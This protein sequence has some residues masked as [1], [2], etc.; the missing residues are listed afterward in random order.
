MQKLSN[1]LHVKLG[2][3]R[4]MQNQLNLCPANGTLYRVPSSIRS[5]L[6]SPVLKKN[7]FEMLFVQCV[8]VKQEMEDVTGIST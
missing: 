8:Q 6:S 5:C 3:R 7:P 2:R 1:G 4:A